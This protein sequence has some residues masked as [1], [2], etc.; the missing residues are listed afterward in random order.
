MWLIA[1]F[2]LPVSTAEQ[3]KNYLQ[4]RKKKLEGEG[5]LPLQKSVYY[6]WCFS[7]QHA[8]SITESLRKACPPEGSIFLL[9]FPEGVGNK[10][11]YV[12]DA[13][14]KSP[15]LKPEPYELF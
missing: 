8:L 10:A 4:F 6:R 13:E 9:N 12:K 14:E 2:D 7:D 11:V 15:L 3:R 1:S 5:F